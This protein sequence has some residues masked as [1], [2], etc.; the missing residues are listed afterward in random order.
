MLVSPPGEDNSGNYL[1]CRQ[2]CCAKVC[3][4]QQGKQLGTA[5]YLQL[6]EDVAQ[7]VFNGARTYTQ[8]L[9]NLLVGKALPQA[10]T[11]FLFTL[12]QLLQALGKRSS[13]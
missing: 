1:V 6:F 10:L 7:M 4:N 2:C 3:L 5:A 12:A 8:L 9:G 13:R 11:D